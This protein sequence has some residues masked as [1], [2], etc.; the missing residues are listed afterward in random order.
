[1]PRRFCEGFS[2]LWVLMAFITHEYICVFMTVGPFTVWSITH[3][4]SS[5]RWTRSCLTT[6]HNSSEPRRTS[7]SKHKHSCGVMWWI[8]PDE[9]TAF[10]SREKAK[11]KEREEAWMKIENLAKS[12]PQVSF[13]IQS[14]ITWSG[15]L[16]LVVLLPVN[17]VTRLR[18][19]RHNFLLT[20]VCFIPSAANGS[21][22]L[23]FLSVF[24]LLSFPL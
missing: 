4:S 24:L 8:V 21:L 18:S 11:L 12:N 22:T 16:R 14:C 10:A 17:H 7:E 5:W 2:S 6:A 1:M 23:M 15:S 19:E 3:W 13:W 20:S 9:N